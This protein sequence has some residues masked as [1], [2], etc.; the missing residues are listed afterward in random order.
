M[1]SVQPTSDLRHDELVLT[2]GCA[3]ELESTFAVAAVMQVA[4]GP[5]PRVQMRHERWDIG[6][7]HHSY[8]DLYG[9]RC[10][11]LMIAAGRSRVAYE[12]QLLVSSPAD[13]VE[14]VHGHL[15]WVCG[16]SNPWTT[17]DA[18]DVALMTSFGPLTLTGS[19][20]QAQAV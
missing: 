18:V 14:A 13:I 6:S 17:R 11:R 15:E 10:E 16:A 19:T 12:A 20:V 1:T 2:V 7:H 8:V 4:P 3:F 5:D 9:N